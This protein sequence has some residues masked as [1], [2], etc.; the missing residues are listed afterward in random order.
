[1]CIVVTIYIEK[2]TRNCLRKTGR[3]EQTYD[4]I[5]KELLERRKKN[6]VN[7]DRLADQK[8]VSASV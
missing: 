8:E 3:K 6:R 4:D 1:M 2:E 7:S 5:F